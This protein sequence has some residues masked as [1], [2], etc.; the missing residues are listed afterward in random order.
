MSKNRNIFLIKLKRRLESLWVFIKLLLKNKL[1]GIA[2]FAIV[3]LTVTAI[4]AP[5]ISPYPDQGQ[6]QVNLEEKFQPPSTKHI[7]GTDELGRDILSRVIFGTRIS[8]VIS[9]ITIVLALVIALPLGLLAGYHGGMVDEIIMRITDVFLSFPPLMIAIVIA[10]FLGPSLPNAVIA[11]A[12][13]WWPWY[14][15]IIRAQVM[16]IREKPFVKASNCIGTN[17]WVILLSHILPNTISPVI[18]QAS[19]DMGGVILTAASL[20]FIG[21]GAQAPT[22]EWGLIISTARTYII[23]AWWYSAFPGLMIFITVLSFNLLGDGFREV[24]DP[25]TRV[26]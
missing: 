8:L 13:A 16:S 1:T 4:F 3:L 5:W 6:G 2:F 21:L 24:F 11:I 17:K 25:R 9:T 7:F 19:M 12:V 14:T 22:P 20:S 10:S 26:R 23:D 15:R 18:I